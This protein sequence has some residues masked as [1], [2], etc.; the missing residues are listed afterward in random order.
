MSHIWLRAEQRQNEERTGLTPGGAAELL[1]QGNSITVEE[2]PMRIFPTRNYAQAGCTIAP[3]GSWVEAPSDAVILGL[4]ELP[5][6]ESPLRHRHIMF[7]HAFKGQYAGRQLLE[8]FR[9]GGG[10]LYDLEH[11][12]DEQGRRVAAFGYWAG[13]VGATVSLKAWAAQQRGVI[14]PPVTTCKSKNILLAELRTELTG[15][16]AVRPSVIVIGALGRVGTGA[17]ELCGA[18]EIVPTKWDMQET[19]HGGP[20]PEILDHSIFLNCILTRPGIPA[21]VSRQTVRAPRQLTVIGDIAC[22]PD[23]DYNPIPIYDRATSWKTPVTRVHTH[24]PLDVMAIDN[25]PS[26]LPREASESFAAQ[27]LPVLACLH[28]PDEG[29]WV[30][31]KAIFQEHLRE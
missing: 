19:A 25:L 21:F 2:S 1:V 26:L 12:V 30:R 18:L 5:A 23:S 8:R 17:V 16:D 15:M 11:L 3:A 20:F 7:G 13:Y 9:R 22:D 14:C 24:P 28:R 31:A 10:T 6:D 27:L 29:T 4:K